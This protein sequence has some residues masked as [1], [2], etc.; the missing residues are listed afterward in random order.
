VAENNG[1]M[2]SVS[3][4]GEKARVSSGAGG[5]LPPQVVML[6]VVKGNNLITVGIG[7]FE[8]DNVATEKIKSAAQKIVA[9]L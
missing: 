6:Y 2:R 3:G 7:G 5:G 8:D 9:Q 4:L 1:A